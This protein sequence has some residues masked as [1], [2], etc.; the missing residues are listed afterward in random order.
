MDEEEKEKQEYL[1]YR[2]AYYKDYLVIGRG[3]MKRFDYFLNNFAL[4]AVARMLDKIETPENQDFLLIPFFVLV[5]LAIN[6]VFKRVRDIGISPWLI[7]VP[8]LALSSV[9]AYLEFTEAPFDQD[10]PIVPIFFGGFI[11]IGLFLI[12]W[13]SQKRDNKYGKYYPYGSFG[14]YKP[15]KEPKQPKRRAL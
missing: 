1:A 5:Y 11:L 8:L 15:P 3:R 6:F 9:P 14:G 12:L 13:P 7:F 2:E 4:N 10:F